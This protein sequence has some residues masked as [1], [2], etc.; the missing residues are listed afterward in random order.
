MRY[1]GQLLARTEVADQC[2]WSLF[3]EPGRQLDDPVKLARQLIADEENAGQAYANLLQVSR[4]L[5]FKELIASGRHVIKEPP[6]SVQAQSLINH[7][8]NGSHFTPEDRKV[9]SLGRLLDLAAACLLRLEAL[10]ST[11][12]FFAES[13]RDCTRDA[14]ISRFEKSLAQIT[15]RTDREQLEQVRSRADADIQRLLE[16]LQARQFVDD[17]VAACRTYAEDL[18]D[19][20]HIENLAKADDALQTSPLELEEFTSALPDVPPPELPLADIVPSGLG[21]IFDAV[22]SHILLQA[23]QFLQPAHEPVQVLRRLERMLGEVLV[24]C[25]VLPCEKR[26]HQE[27]PRVPLQVTSL[28]KLTRDASFRDFFVRVRDDGRIAFVDDFEDGH[29]VDL[30]ELRTYTPSRVHAAAQKQ[31]QETGKEQLQTGRQYLFSLGRTPRLFGSNPAEI[32]DGCVKG[33]SG[34]P[35]VYPVF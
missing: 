8:R 18:R 11:S 20:G 2:V 23:W 24:G 12:E 25:L 16:T 14:A 19:N 3:L 22:S 9:A 27:N 31:K 33:E 17:L 5:A 10:R 28:D 6:A 1:I 13:P 29:Y 26:R 7:V 34:S 32:L 30:F 4:Y 21:E 15:A 35:V